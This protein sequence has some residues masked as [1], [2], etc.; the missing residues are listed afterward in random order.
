V[1]ATRNNSSRAVRHTTLSDGFE[2][3]YA[4][5][6]KRTQFSLRKS[7]SWVFSYSPRCIWET[8]AGV[9]FIDDNGGGAL[10]DPVQE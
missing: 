3:V 8:A 6:A 7:S 9:E 5:F 1:V 4:F 2:V 10:R